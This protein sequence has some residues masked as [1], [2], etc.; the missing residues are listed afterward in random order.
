MDPKGSR[1]K[2]KGGKVAKTYKTSLEEREK[3]EKKL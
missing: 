3:Y 2:A 1:L